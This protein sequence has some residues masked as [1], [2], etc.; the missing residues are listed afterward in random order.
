MIKNL[1]ILF[2]SI[3]LFFLTIKVVL[4]ESLQDLAK[5][6]NSLREQIS[7]LPPPDPGLAT[8][9]V[10]NKSGKATFGRILNS[11]EGSKVVTFIDSSTGK[12]NTGVLIGDATAKQIQA[13]QHEIRVAEAAAEQINA[14]AKIDIALKGVDQATAFMQESYSKG[15]IDG[16]IAALAV[17]DVAMSDV[18][19]NVPYDFRSQ[20]IKEGENFTKDEMQKISSITK[21]IG[22]KK[23]KNYEELKEYIET[24]KTSGLEVEEITKKIILSGIKTPK[25]NYYYEQA[26]NAELRKNLSDSIK[27]SAIIGKSSDEVDLSVRQAAAFQSGDPKKIRAIEIEKYGKAAGLSKE[28]INK[29]VNAV[30]NGDIEFEKQIS[31]NIFQKLKSNSNYQVAAMSDAEIDALVDEGIAVEKAAYKILNSGIDFSQGTN[32]S[33]AKKLAD[34]IEKIL[35]GKVDKSKIQQIKYNISRTQ[36]EITNKENVAANL[37]AEINGQDYVD[38]LV[39]MNIGSKSIA[40]QAAVFEAGIN[41]NMEAFREVTRDTNKMSLNTMSTKEVNQLTNIYGNIIKSQNLSNQIKQDIKVS[42]ATKVITETTATLEEAKQV[43]KIASNNL[44]VKQNEVGQLKNEYKELLEGQKIGESSL[45]EVLE[46]Q[47]NLAT[48]SKEL[49]SLQNTANQASTAAIDA[50]KAAGEAR[51]VANIAKETASDLSDVTSVA[52]SEVSKEVSQVTEAVQKNIKEQLGEAK[53]YAQELAEIREMVKQETA[54]VKKT[55]GELREELK[56]EIEK[57]GIE[58][59]VANLQQKEREAWAEYGKYGFSDPGWAAS[60]TK[61]L[62]ASYKL[63]QAKL[64]AQGINVD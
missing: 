56:G 59:T 63:G 45:N 64:K 31:K 28:M 11:S 27:Y 42:I 29:G 33:Q 62:D 36:F 25:L 13:S 35:D 26:S 2:L 34:D 6:L 32:A 51:A 10:I 40:E 1:K 47:R 60:R 57:S 14:V 9:T 4:S 38:A 21:N 50:A 20:V 24:A 22:N 55:T 43:S 48:V 54:A 46:A 16:A 61:H 30:Y 39:Q 12:M 58:E 7:Q 37:I 19:N 44:N 23:S 3:L 41:G 52:V 5:E 53:T 18:A 15:D 8:V 17:I 49:S